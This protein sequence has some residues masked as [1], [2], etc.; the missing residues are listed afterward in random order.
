MTGVSQFCWGEVS[1]TL[2]CYALQDPCVFKS[3]TEPGVG[4]VIPIF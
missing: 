4:S 1:G 2:S 3:L